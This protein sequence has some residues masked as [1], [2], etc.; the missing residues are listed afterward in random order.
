MGNLFG[1]SEPNLN[2]IFVGKPYKKVSLMIVLFVT[3]NEATIIVHLLSLN[4]ARTLTSEIITFLCF[5]CKK[6]P[7]FLMNTST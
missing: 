5:F 2:S 4:H 6:H 3:I 1:A 7:N